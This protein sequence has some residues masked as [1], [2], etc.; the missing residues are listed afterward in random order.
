[1]N[2]LD[3]GLAV[4]MVYST[5]RAAMRGL[6]RVVLSIAGLVIG[7]FVAGWGYRSLAPHLHGLV[8][9]PQL[10]LLIAFLLLLAGVIFVF[11]IIA[12]VTHRAVSAVGLSALNRVLGGAFGLLRG[13]V[14]GITLLATLVAFLPA[15]TWV[16]ESLLA[17]YLLRGVHAVSF[18]M[19]QEMRRRLLLGSSAIKHESGDW[20]K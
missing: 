7:L 2:P 12:L 1:M 20:I 11:H 15:S 16:S 19:P 17:P 5:V 13:A 4:I 18:V 8:T 14:I 3:W 9:Q 10:Q 6:V